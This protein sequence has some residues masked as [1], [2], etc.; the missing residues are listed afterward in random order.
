MGGNKGKWRLIS[1]TRLWDQTT[2]VKNDSEKMSPE[3]SKTLG[4]LTEEFQIIKSKV[5]AQHRS[6]TWYAFAE[7]IIV[8]VFFVFYHL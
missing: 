6:Y 2:C 3:V 7:I 4:I 1:P 5:W 8:Y